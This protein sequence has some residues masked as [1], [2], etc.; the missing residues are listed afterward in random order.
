MGKRF[1][2]EIDYIPEAVAWAHAQNIDHIRRTVWSFSGYS[3]AAI[4]SGGSYSAASFLAEQHESSFGEL[5]RAM[6]PLQFAT[7]RREL[8]RTAAALVSAEGKNSDILAAAESAH[9]RGLHGFA[10]TLT[11]SNPLQEY[12]ERT[13]ALT[14]V[15]FQMPWGKDGYLATNSLLASVILL[16]RAYARSDTDVIDHSDL[17]TGEWLAKQRESFRTN[18]TLGRLSPG[19]SILI[20]H[21]NFGRIAAIDIESRFQKP[22]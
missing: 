19:Q 5:S 10:L 16:A 11:S 14:P 6:T 9:A 3:I 2:E 21:G 12:C 17:V 20:L 22:R 18:D 8:S 4:G 15:S 7:S 13:G 1:S